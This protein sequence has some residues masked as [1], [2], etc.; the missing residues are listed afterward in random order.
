MKINSKI[1]FTFFTTGIF[2]SSCKKD[3]AIIPEVKPEYEN[4]YGT[5]STD[6]ISEAVVS[7]NGTMMCVGYTNGAGAGGF[8]GWLVNSDTKGNVIWQ[9]TFGGSGNDFLKSILKTNDG[10]Y[11]LTGHTFSGTIGAEDSWAIKLSS[12]GMLEWEKKYGGQNADFCFNAVQLEDNT[13]LL[14]AST[15]SFGAGSLDHVVLKLDASG[16]LLTYKTYGDNSVQ[17]Y[18]K[19]IRKPDGNF[20]LCGRTDK[21]G[22]ADIDVLEINSNLDSIREF[23]FGTYE[24]EESKNIICLSDGNFML[25]GH[26]AG[27]GHPEHNFYAVKFSG[28]G[29]IIWEKNYGSPQHDGAEHLLQMSEDRFV[30]TGR[31]DGNYGN[32]EDMMCVII[33]QNGNQV[34]SFYKGSTGSDQ[35]YFSLKQDDYFFTVGR[36][37]VTASNLDAWFLFTPIE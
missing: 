14:A 22:N 31:G 32:G 18:G 11:L 12:T 23:T 2:I 35:A 4:T 36:K 26:T 30:L 17:G 29:T 21:N 13:Y 6:M 15:Q 3:V 7:N 20:F 34:K 28:T 37:E 16:N 10:G 9:Q 8:D 33:D 1:L 24:Y 25:A 5:N 27:F 19:I